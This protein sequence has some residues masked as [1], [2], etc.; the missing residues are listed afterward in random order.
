MANKADADLLKAKGAAFLKRYRDI[1]AGNMDIGPADRL[2]QSL[3]LMAG[4]EIPQDELHIW[5]EEV[6]DREECGAYL[7]AMAQQ[8]RRRLPCRNRCRPAAPLWRR[9]AGPLTAC[10]L[11][12][13]REPARDGGGDAPLFIRSADK[14]GMRPS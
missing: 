5:Q 1:G 7:G 13:S 11:P 3:S 10:S 2:R 9:P 6:G 14:A 8:S 4:H 12:P